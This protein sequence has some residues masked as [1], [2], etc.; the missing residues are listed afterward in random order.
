MDSRNGLLIYL[1]M[2]EML[3]VHWHVDPV[4]F[5]IGSFGLRW[6]SILFVSGFILGWFI[7]RGFF[8]REKISEILLDPLLY[9]L[10][11][12]T[13]VGARL[14]H[15]LSAGVLLR[16][17]AGIPGDIHAMERRPRKP[18]RHY[19]V[20]LCNALVCTSLRP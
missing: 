7:F 15:L 4:I 1:L 17:L 2:F 14:G 10:L 5:H 16:K 9:T 12:G 3:F 11:I 8:R 18:W 6:Y 20:V 13:I 19:C